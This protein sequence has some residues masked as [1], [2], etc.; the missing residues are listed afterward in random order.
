MFYYH[1]NSFSR[2]VFVSATDKM[3]CVCVCV[4]VCVL[5]EEREI[6]GL[7]FSVKVAQLLTCPFLTEE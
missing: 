6:V 1:R 2:G 5:R 3:L 4:C 7:E